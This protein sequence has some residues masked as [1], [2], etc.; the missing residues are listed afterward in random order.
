MHCH[1]LF[2]K[3]WG[4]ASPRDVCPCPLLFDI[5]IHDLPSTVAGKFDYADD[6]A[7][8]HSAR[9]QQELEGR[10]TNPGHGNSNVLS[11]EVKAETQHG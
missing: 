8:L 3:Y 7:I 6:L 10:L 9:D 1:T 11:P 4:D 2:E 5:Y